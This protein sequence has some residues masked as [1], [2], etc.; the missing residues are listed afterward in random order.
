MRNQSS[1]ISLDTNERKRCAR[2]RTTKK[3]QES[4]DTLRATPILLAK[5]WQRKGRITGVATFEQAQA[6]IGFDANTATN[7]GFDARTVT[8]RTQ[9]LIDRKSVV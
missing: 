1:Q 5:T 2:G 7:I 3:S 6:V 4:T 9:Q 8:M